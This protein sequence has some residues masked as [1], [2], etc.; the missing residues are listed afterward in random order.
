MKFILILL[1]PLLLYSQQ[2]QQPSIDSLKYNLVTLEGSLRNAND[3]INQLTRENT[4]LHKQLEAA[5][6]AKTA[7]ADVTKQI[8]QTVE[9]THAQVKVQESKR[10]SDAQRAIADR[11]EIAERTA[12]LVRNQA[13]YERQLTAL[14]RDLREVVKAQKRAA[15]MT[16][17]LG[18]FVLCFSGVIL[19]TAGRMNTLWRTSSGL[20]N[21]GPARE[22]ILSSVPTVSPVDS[23]A[24]PPKSAAPGETSTAT[25]DK[26]PTPKKNTKF[27]K[28]LRPVSKRAPKQDAG[29]PKT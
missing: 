8:K 9:A 23:T 27:Q 10:E 2:Q 18:V 28:T 22:S 4:D 16:V 17:V 25:E 21:H 7:T 11:A 14:Q 3:K 13:E 15:G 24:P 12:A 26:F 1:V 20:V 6:T 19:Y 5:L 29:F